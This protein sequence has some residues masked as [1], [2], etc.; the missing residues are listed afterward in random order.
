MSKY[1]DLIQD[2][3]NKNYEKIINNS[4]TLLKDK[5]NDLYLNIIIAK[6]FFKLRDFQTALRIL[7][8]LTQLYPN[9]FEPYYEIGNILRDLKNYDPSIKT[10]HLAYKI[11]K[12]NFSLLNNI[13]SVYQLYNKPYLALK[14][15]FK[16]LGLERNNALLSF[17]I[18]SIYRELNQIEL[19]REY[20]ALIFR[21]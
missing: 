2:F 11:N 15:Y 1:K 5:P 6:S 8:K 9:K 21:R 17:N 4:K 12:K 14:Y 7:S 19:S 10:Y 3:E 20:L 16:A 13:G 18:G